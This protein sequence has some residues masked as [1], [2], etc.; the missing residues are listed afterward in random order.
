MG[1]TWLDAVLLTLAVYRVSHMLATEE[2]PFLAFQWL[3]DAANH[4]AAPW[5]AHGVS[6]VLCVSFWLGLVAGWLAFGPVYGLA[7]AGACLVLHRGLY[8]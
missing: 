5:V 1:V 7:I 6:C 4:R 2:G 8:R 3:R